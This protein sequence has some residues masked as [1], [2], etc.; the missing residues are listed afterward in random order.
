MTRQ[1]ILTAVKSH[2]DG[3]IAHK[4]E[5]DLALFKEFITLHP[6]DI[7]EFLSDL[8]HEQME[9]LFKML[10]PELAAQVFEYLS[11]PVKITILG[12]LDDTKRVFLLK[13]ISVDDLADFFDELSDDDLK[14]Y[15]KLLH[16]REREKVCS[17]L[18]FNPESAG[19]IMDTEVLSLMQDF[20]VQK[21]IQILQ[22]LQPRRDLHQQIFVTNN[23]NQLVGHIHLEDLVLKSPQTRL[24]SILRKNELVAHVDED[25]EDIAHKMVHYK[26]MTV[27]VVGY[28][29]VFLGVIPSETLVT[30]LE[31][32][33]SEDVYRMSALAPMKE[34]YFDTPFYRLFYERSAILIIL[35]LVQSLSSIILQIYEALLAGFLFS[36]VPMLS[37]TG[38]NASNQTSA[39][40]IQGITAGDIREEN[41]HRFLRRELLMALMIAG[42]L[43]V[44]SFI[45]VYIMYRR[46]WESIAIS[47]SLFCIVLTAIVLGSLMPLALKKLKID[48]AYSA[49]PVL[50]TIMDVLGILLYC[51]LSRLI[52]G[53]LTMAGS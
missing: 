18:Q 41:I 46:L 35:L 30:V 52:L 5:V 17:L 29:N 2:I 9:K 36:F 13:H 38:G 25:R 7:A 44:F 26:L 21:S 6:A 47:S 50:A 22:R 42:I 4:T 39:L 28:N 48:P 49:G 16:K 3:V 15:L 24:S 37:S 8:N 31:Q 33:S 11:N 20:T 10:S 45:R 34:S 14:K 43:G 27:P 53:D 12:F 1:E 19:G 40:V 51:Y 32:E 23:H